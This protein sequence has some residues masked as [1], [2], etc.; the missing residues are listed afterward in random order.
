MISAGHVIAGASASVTV[1]Y[2]LQFDESPLTSVTI[3][4]TVVVPKGY[5]AALL[6]VTE[7]IFGHKKK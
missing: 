5:V 1:T 7:V 4:V 6:F 3:H 2:W